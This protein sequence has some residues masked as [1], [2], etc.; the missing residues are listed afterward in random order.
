MK[1]AIIG[2]V[3]GKVSEYLE[4]IKRYTH[5]IQ[6]GDFS[7]KRSDYI[8]Q[9]MNGF[10]KNHKILQGNHDYYPIEGL[11]SVLEDYNSL[12]LGGKQIF[13]VRGASSIDRHMRT[14]GVD[15]FREEELTYLQGRDCLGAYEKAKPSIVVSHDCPQFVAQTLFGISESSFTRILLQ[16]LFYIHKPKLWVFGHHHKSKDLNLQNCRFVCLNELEIFEL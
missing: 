2:D 5:S 12:E 10:S 9:E 15:W 1:L 4:I 11:K 6:L 16:Q 13:Y 8:I 14:E 7:I 3:H